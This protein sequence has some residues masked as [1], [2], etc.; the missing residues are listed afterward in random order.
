M[1]TSNLNWTAGASGIFKDLPAETY[2]AA[3]GVSHSMLKHM[4][5]PARLP[6]YL[7]EKQEPTAA[8]IM[9]TL[10]HQRILEPAKPLPQIE[11]KP[12]D[13][14]FS[15]REGK[16]W[17]DE[18][19]GKLILTTPEYNTLNGC[20]ESVANHPRC[21]EIFANGASEISCFAEFG[22]ARLLRKC[23]I[24]F[25]P[26][27]NCLVDIKT[28]QN[29]KAD[30]DEFSR[31]LYK[32]RYYTQAAYYLDLWNHLM[33]ET[34]RKEL[35]VFVV[36]EKESPYLVATYFVDAKTIEVGREKN[37]SDLFTLHQCHRTKQW[38]GYIEEHRSIG[39]PS[40]DLR[41]EEESE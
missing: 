34:E 24:D 6:V 19:K 10:V 3:P 12:E 5:P 16:A 40:W 37:L 2:F 41:R 7:T 9:G 29:E 15:T 18:R 14:K 36:V 38:L 30:K 28:V 31:I 13:M 23:R 27:G 39:I 11:V 22:G 20:V 4:N 8:M 21:R 26:A 1:D 32:Q 33:G 25:V 35:F 17:R